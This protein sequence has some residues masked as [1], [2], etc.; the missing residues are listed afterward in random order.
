MPLEALKPFET[1]MD[2][3]L[4]YQKEEFEARAVVCWKALR[5]CYCRRAKPSRKPGGE[6]KLA[7]RKSSKR[8]LQERLPERLRKSARQRPPKPSQPWK[9]A[10][11]KSGTKTKKKKEGRAALKKETRE[12]VGQASGKRKEACVR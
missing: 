4:R 10:G 8:L 11:S 9:P 12:A 5:M 2:S 1:L 6:K 7:G 3:W